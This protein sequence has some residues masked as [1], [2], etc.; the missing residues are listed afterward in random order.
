VI[1]GLQGSGATS[2]RRP[3][4]AYPA[5]SRAPSSRR[6]RPRRA[7][8]GCSIRLG[9]STRPLPRQRVAGSTCLRL[10]PRSKNH[11]MHDQY[12][13]RTS[14]HLRFDLARR[15]VGS[16]AATAV[17]SGRLAKGHV[18]HVRSH[19]PK[20]NTYLRPADKLE[21]RRSTVGAPVISQPVG[22]P[23]RDGRPDEV[24]SRP[25]LWGRCQGWSASCTTIGC[26]PGWRRRAW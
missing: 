21:P 17:R 6:A 1:A 14:L 26:G 3:M 10:R 25:V 19:I 4:R 13:S 2:V 7:P 12:Y 24:I 15:L 9:R 23:L 18:R 11:E 5:A 8:A 20:T 16:G 22:R